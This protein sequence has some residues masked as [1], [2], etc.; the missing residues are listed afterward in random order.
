MSSKYA[1]V[2][3]G[4]VENLVIWDAEVEIWQ[5]PE[6]AVAVLI[7]DGTTVSIGST[8]DGAQFKDQAPS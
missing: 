7:P 2:R 4:V 3:E 6:G 1:V 5:P 8:Y